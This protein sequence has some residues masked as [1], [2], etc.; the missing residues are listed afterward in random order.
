M[1]VCSVVLRPKRATLAA[2]VTET[3]AAL[4]TLSPGAIFAILADDPGAASDTVNAF[5]GQF[6]IEAANAAAVVDAVA[7]HPVFV[8]EEISAAVAVQN[9]SLTPAGGLV[10]RQSMADRVFINADGTARQANADG[11]MINL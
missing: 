8:L 3:A 2:T 7:A 4:D 6:M 10:S 11:I 9:A 5:V 1:L